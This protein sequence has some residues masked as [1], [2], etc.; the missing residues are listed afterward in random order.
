MIE[1]IVKLNK[2]DEAFFGVHEKNNMSQL[3]VFDFTLSKDANNFDHV[4]INKDLRDY[5]KAWTFQLEKS[6]DGY[7]HYQGRFSLRSKRTLK[8]CLSI[9][10]CELDWKGKIM[11]TARSNTRNFNYV[12]KADTRI[13][14]PWTDK[15]QV[16][17]EEY[18]PRQFRNIELYAWQQKV[19]ELSETFIDRT[20]NVI[21]D[22][23]GNNGKSTLASI[24]ELKYNGIDL[25]PINDMKELISTMCN[26]CIDTNNRN[27][28][29]VFIDMTRAMDKSRLYGIYTAI[30]QIK[31]GKL[32]DLRYKYKKYWIDSPAIWVFSNILPDEELLSRDRWKIWQIIDKDL[33]RYN[34]CIIE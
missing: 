9:F 20:I 19:I 32:Y 6:E 14:G 4:K 11:P 23:K 22:E 21:Y 1:P 7:E 33:T 29:I 28:K 31:K 15:D 26:I 25:P 5:C 27:P 2:W 17:E 10:V 8:S 18:I 16:I 13:A 30:E 34:E 12:Q 3:N 24:V